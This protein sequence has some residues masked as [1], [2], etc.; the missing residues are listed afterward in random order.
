MNTDLLHE[1]CS[2][3]TAPYVE[4]AVV[5]YVH[6]F[7]AKRKA[8]RLKADAFGNLLLTLPGKH[9]ATGSKKPAATLPRLVLVAHM[10]HPGFVATA[11]LP[12]GRLQAEFRGG[13][14]ADYVRGCRVRFFHDDTETRATVVEVQEADHGRA[15]LCLLKVPRPVPP[16]ACGMFDLGTARTRD[17]TFHCRACDDVAGVASALAT[18]DALHRRPPARDVA[19]LLTRAEEVGFVGALAAV[20][21]GKLLKKSDQ[22]ISIETSAENAAAVRG[23]GV[24]VRVGDRT[25]VFNSGLTYQITQAADALSRKDETFKY[26]RA[27]MPGGTC[28]ATV[29]DAFGLTAAA[30]CVPLANYHNMNRRTRKLAAEAIDLADWANMVRLFVT[31][32]RETQTDGGEALRARL[33]DVLA[34]AQSRLA[35]PL[36]PMPAAKGAEPAKPAKKRAKQPQ[37]PMF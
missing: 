32:A 9:A 11:M 35:D 15:G 17:G 20:L 3:P 6:A 22:I 12:D 28:E 36:A 13:V 5:A 2:L 14:M 30:V 27:L 25:S 21:E 18:I 19:V 34:R 29:F 16:A 24:V 4:D 1:V 33:R 10:D 26:Q 37:K 31:L 8:L 7:A 23:Q